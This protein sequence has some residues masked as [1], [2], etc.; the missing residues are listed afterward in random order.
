MNVHRLS[1]DELS[2]ESAALLSQQSF[3]SSRSFA[4]VWRGMDGRPVVWLAETGGDVFAMMTAVEF[5]IGPLARLQSMPDG[6]PGGVVLND[7]HKEHHSEIA[8]ALFKS[9]RS[10]GYTKVFVFD[11]HTT[12]T[13]PDGFDTVT[14]ETSVI[15]ISAPD[16]LPPDKKLQ[17]EIRKAQREGVTVEFFDSARDLDQ[18][19]ELTRSTERRHGDSPRY[20][21]RFFAA[22][23][24]LAGRDDRILWTVVRDGDSLAASHI[25][26]CD[27]SDALYWQSCLDKGQS[28]KKPNQALLFD[29]V[30][31]LR[32]AGVTR[33]NLGQSPPEAEGLDQFKS[34]WGGK[35]YRYPS[36]V[37]KSLLGRLR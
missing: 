33:L 6:L 1:I 19:I 29:A 3:F 37:Y 10:F 13:V 26:L 9:V 32:A 20:G 21:D 27:R 30:E 15:D 7:N 14:C 12:L 18:F 28:A 36:Y 5:G 16:W 25:Y 11:Y 35:T 24:D 31:Q 8:K 2:S 4:E 23:A 34:K 22:L 17:S